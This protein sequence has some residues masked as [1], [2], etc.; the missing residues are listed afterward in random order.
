MEMLKR[1]VN[2]GFSGGEKKRTEILQMARARAVAVRAR[3]D[4]QPA[5][6]STRCAIVADG[7]NALRGPTAPCSSS[8]TTSG[9]SNYIVP[10][11]GARAGERP[12][13][14][15]RRQGARARTRE[16]RLCRLPG[17]GS[18]NMSVA[19]Q[20][21]PETAGRPTSVQVLKTK[22]ETGAGPG[23]RQGRASAPRRRLAAPASACG[24]M[25]RSRPKGLPHRRVE[26]WKF[27]DLRAMM[28]EGLPARGPTAG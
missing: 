25:V 5:S 27:T 12:H 16:V 28:R 11:R 23:V 15:V 6:T 8:R 24:G 21:K 17:R 22:A 19:Q 2:V 4:R 14:R 20:I 13:P 9:F 1:P 26:E 10:D 18:R 3:R 7:V